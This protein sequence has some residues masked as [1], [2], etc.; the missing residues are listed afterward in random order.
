MSRVR[1]C[2]L[3]F[4]QVAKHSKRMRTIK[5]F[6]KTAVCIVG[7]YSIMKK[8]GVKLKCR[9]KFQSSYITAHKFGCNLAIFAIQV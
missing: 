3:G 5:H 8:F 6:I 1:L 4:G 9:I 2:K 7:N